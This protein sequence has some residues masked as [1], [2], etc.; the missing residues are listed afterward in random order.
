MNHLQAGYTKCPF[1]NLSFV[2]VEESW[3]Q[4]HLDELM[5]GDS[6]PRARSTRAD[7]QIRGG[8]GVAPLARG[9]G[10]TVAQNERDNDPTRVTDPAQ[11]AENLRSR[12]Q[13]AVA[14][15]NRRAFPRPLR[16]VRPV[17]W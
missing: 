15:N 7:E 5:Y 10:A 4:A 17:E 1:C 2:N 3:A 6:D 12:W 11:E 14:L 9:G 16:D 13:I 8:E